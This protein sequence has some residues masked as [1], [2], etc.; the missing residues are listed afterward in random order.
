MRHARARIETSAIA[1]LEYLW[2]RGR[3]EKWAGGHGSA[4]Y[5]CSLAQL[6]IGVA[7][8]MGWNGIPRQSSDTSI[9]AGERR[10]RYE[11]QRASF[12]RC[13][14]KSVQRWLDWLA[15]AGLVSHTP[16]QDE[17]GFV[18]D[19]HRAARLSAAASRAARRGLGAALGLDGARAPPRRPRA[20]ARPYGDPAPRAPDP[21]RSAA[22]AAPRAGAR[23]PPARSASASAPWPPRASRRPLRHIGRIPS[24]PRLR[25][26]V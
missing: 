4:R 11:R 14:R 23:W 22:R 1:M 24:E 6:V 3:G 20:P 17:E 8:I 21:A 16:Q 18:A 12:V 19:D 5:G 15:D 9:P 10:R 26:G 2:R 25:F 7:E 13:H